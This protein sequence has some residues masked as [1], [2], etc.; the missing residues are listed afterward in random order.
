MALAEAAICGCVKGAITEIATVVGGPIVPIA[1]V[2]IA[3]TAAIASTN[4][5]DHGDD[6]R[7][8]G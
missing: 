8:D 5:S 2:A 3:V 4:S 1:L 6:E 7:K